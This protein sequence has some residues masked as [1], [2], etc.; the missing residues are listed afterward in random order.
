MKMMR[1]LQMRTG[2]AIPAL[3]IAMSFVAYVFPSLAAEQEA[4][5]A[6]QS[7]FQPIIQKLERWDAEAAWQDVKP[8]LAKEPKNPELQE[9]ASEIAFFRGDYE[10]ALTYAKS[11]LELGGEDEGR[12]G[13]ALLIESTVGVLKSYKR[14][15]TAHFVISLDEKQDAILIGY[16][17]DTL[18]K[19]YQAIAQQ[20]GFQPGEK[21]RV[22]LFP[23][24]RAFYYTSTLSARDIEITGAVGLCKFNKLMFLSPR[25]LVHGYRWLD[26][27]SHEYMHYMIT[28]L[29][30][31]KAPIWFHEGLAEHEEAR[32]RNE[33]P[34]LSP[35]HQTLLARALADGR[36]ISFER[37]DPGLVKLETPEDVQ[38]AYAEAQSAIAFI[39]EKRG[40][41][42]LRE[43][44]RQMATS[45]EKGAGDAIKAAMGWSLDEFQDK[46]KEF[47]ASKGLKEMEGV[48][49]HRYKLK[50]G[51]ADD[52]RMEMREIKSM[53]A[54]NRAHLGDLLQERGRLEAALLEYRRALADTRDSVPIL[55]RLSEAL[56]KL[57]RLDEALEQLHRAKRLAPD[58]PNTYASLGKIYLKRKDA[59]K[60]QEAYEDAI[61]INPFNP[62]IHKD[63]AA[64]YEMLG[65]SESA[66]KERDIFNTLNK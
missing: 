14:Y 60:A 54:R 24:T 41:N 35:V 39:I 4:V 36:L 43:V 8:L 48:S 15:E 30:A 32:W 45:G 25:A 65:R 37:M 16:L 56:I 6:A 33:P 20:Y 61:Q 42:G 52:D 59:K 50:E 5:Q 62:D 58:H 27:I 31:N 7:R 17:T 1:C 11:A 49:V 66:L 18:E 53:V 34:Q 13:F 23:D 57:D 21:V 26:A 46:W 19:T 9:L 64:V 3:L 10:E 55:N 40:H 22:E 38:L 2:I 12:K 44:M 29:T 51:L 47:L 63:L 28:K